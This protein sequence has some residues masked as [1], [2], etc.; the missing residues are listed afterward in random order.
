[1]FDGQ[2]P[3][4]IGKTTIWTGPFSS[5]QTVSHYQRVPEGTRGDM[6]IPCSL[7][8][9]IS[10]NQGYMLEKMLATKTQWDEHG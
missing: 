6:G 8:P 1:M 5:S 7:R 10:K 3:F 4:L 2:L 9:L